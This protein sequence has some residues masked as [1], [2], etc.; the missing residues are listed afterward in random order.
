MNLVLPL[1]SFVVAFMSV[2]WLHPKMV[3]IAREK[4]IT[5]NPDRRKL[6]R[7]PIP[8]LGGV[9]VFF[10]IVMGLGLSG[11][12]LSGEE[13]AAVI[14]L[15]TLMLYTGT[16]DD[17]VGLTPRFRFGVEFIASIVLIGVCGYSI[18]DFHGLWGLETIPSW[19]G[20]P[21]TIVAT[22]GII[23]AINLI[24]GV[25]G[26]S[27]GYC[28]MACSVFGVWFFLSGDVMMSVLAASCIGAL[29]PF[30]LHNV[31]GKRSKMFIGDGGTLLMGMMMS[32]YVLR[33]LDNPQCGSMLPET[34]EGSELGLIPFTLAV[35]SIPVFDTVRVMTTR[36]IRGG[37]P[38]SPDKRHLHHAFIE[39]GFSHFATTLS[40]LGLNMLIVGGWYVLYVLGCSTDVQFWFVTSFGI[41]FTTGVRLVARTVVKRKNNANV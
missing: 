23:N 41:I 30:F 34:R 4:G 10:G 5:D 33:V 18:T 8:V 11:R 14:A 20:L 36:I 26:L 7:E 15:L 16:M 38:F 37:S 9:A 35:M 39:M 13:V 21:L 6:Q 19:V 3:R 29:I 25:D 40:I 22:V 1:A 17:I 32:M 27:S 28:I 12:L 24:D 31:F 2:L